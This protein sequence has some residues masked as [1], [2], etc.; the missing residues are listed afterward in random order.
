M[1]KLSDIET[2]ILYIYLEIDFPYYFA[3]A[4]MARTPN[5]MLYI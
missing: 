2:V 3:N 4:K 1:G 5:I